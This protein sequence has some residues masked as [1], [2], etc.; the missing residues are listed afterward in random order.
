VILNVSELITNQAIEVARQ[1]NVLDILLS[2]VYTS[3]PNISL[4]AMRAP[5]EGRAAL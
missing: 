1:E 5:E 3:T 2:S 4:E